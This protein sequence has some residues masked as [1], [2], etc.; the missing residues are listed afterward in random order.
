[1]ERSRSEATQLEGGLGGSE[2][3]CASE[4]IV[5]WLGGVLSPAVAIAN[6]GDKVGATAINLAQT[7]AERLAEARLLLGDAPAQVDNSD[8]HAACMCDTTKRRQCFQHEG[9]AFVVHIAKCGRDKDAHIATRHQFVL[10]TSSRR[11]VQIAAIA[12][13]E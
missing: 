13:R 12:R 6:E 3:K 8:K 9:L 5:A 1:M 4:E 2:S 10:M 11:F 7:G